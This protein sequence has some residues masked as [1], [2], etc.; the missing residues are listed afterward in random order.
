MERNVGKATGIFVGVR[1]RRQ[2]FRRVLG[3][4]VLAEP[5]QTKQRGPRHSRARQL[6]NRLFTSNF[7]ST[8]PFS[9]QA[10]HLH[11][12]QNGRFVSLSN[13]AK[14]GLRAPL[15]G[16]CIDFQNIASTY[17]TTETANTPSIRFRG[18]P[19]VSLRHTDSCA[20]QFV[21]FYYKTFDENR[22]G[23]QAL[24]VRGARAAI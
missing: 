17:P 18:G 24:Y 4:A 3:A 20:A 19:C 16:S 7:T 13:D 6:R 15:T 11:Y 1:R 22:G 23:L 2:L 14:C 10:I 12:R 21:Q 5:H 8:F 9:T